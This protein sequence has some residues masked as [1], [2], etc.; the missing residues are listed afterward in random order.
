MIR[1][2]VI[3]LAAG[4]AVLTEAHARPA[5]IAG[6]ISAIDGRTTECLVAR[7]R[8]ETIARYWEDLLVG[9]TL[10]AKGDCRIEIMPRD[11]PRRWTIMESNSPTEMV[12]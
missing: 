12:V 6:Y 9:D 11:G 7:G 2:I 10:I 4:C 3:V 5:P 1:I 8:K